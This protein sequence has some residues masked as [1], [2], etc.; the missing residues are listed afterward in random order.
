MEFL[1]WSLLSRH[2]IPLQ[3]G[4]N[5]STRLSVVEDNIVCLLSVKINKEVGRITEG[6]DVGEFYDF[7]LHRLYFLF[8]LEY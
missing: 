5:V 3:L 2:M 7:N 4:V 8:C 1:L 6:L